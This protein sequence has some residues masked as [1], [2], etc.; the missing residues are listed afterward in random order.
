MKAA[1]RK[2]TFASLDE[3]ML[4]VDRLLRGHTT[5]GNWSLGQI[6]SHL[7]QAF[8]FTIDGF[9]PET[10]L[11]WIIR[12]TI[13]R[14]ILWRILRTGRFTEGMRMPKK[15]EPVPGTD[16]RAEAEALR[17]ALQRF[18]AHTG[19]LVEQPLYGP[20]SRDVWDQFHCI[21]CA[22]HLGFAIPGEDEK[23]TSPG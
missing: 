2:L 7:A 12:K 4:D 8:R 21:H 11:P 17:A 14:F 15:W 6:C 23:K 3:V 5:V 13:G 16:A 18:A 19:P 1:R 9:P 10:R 22:H 20:V